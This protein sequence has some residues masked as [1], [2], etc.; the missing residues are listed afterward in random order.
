LSI[1]TQRPAKPAQQKETPSQEANKPTQAKKIK[2]KEGTFILFFAIYVPPC[3]QKKGNTE[4]RR[5]GHYKKVLLVRTKKERRE[6]GLK[7]EKI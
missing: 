2:K 5:D 3:S 4:F 7:H 1:K 6:K